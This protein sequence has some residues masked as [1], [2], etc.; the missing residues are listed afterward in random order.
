MIG[1]QRSMMDK[2]LIKAQFM[3]RQAIQKH[4]ELFADVQQE[5]MKKME[6]QNGSE[7]GDQKEEPI[8]SPSGQ[9]LP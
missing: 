4:N 5:L 1:K 9:P 3:A 7:T 2:A 6:S 8:G